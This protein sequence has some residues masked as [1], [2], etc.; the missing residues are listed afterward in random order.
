M[1][2]S[3]CLLSI[4]RLIEQIITYKDEMITEYFLYSKRC[5]SSG[6][7]ISVAS[8]FLVNFSAQA[9]TGDS[10]IPFKFWNFSD[11]SPIN[12]E[13]KC[14]HYYLGNN[15]FTTRAMLSDFK[16]QRKIDSLFISSNITGISKSKFISGPF[17]ANSNPKKDSV[18]FK[19]SNS[20]QNIPAQLADI[21]RV[22][23]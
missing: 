5:I 3:I 10:V 19:F 6:S 13:T 21:N 23:Q 16:N 9:S 22:H 12:S 1:I 17:C 4:H 14:L 8:S 7:T 15:N 18:N 20:R 2:L 11:G